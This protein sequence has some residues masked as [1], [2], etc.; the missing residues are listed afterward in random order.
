[1]SA[2]KLACMDKLSA[3]STKK[4]PLNLFKPLTRDF[5]N[6]MSE[7]CQTITIHLS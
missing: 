2:C 4:K 1:M 5:M 3:L 7:N 6:E